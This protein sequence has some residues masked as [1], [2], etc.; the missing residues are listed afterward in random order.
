MFKNDY[1]CDAN[2]ASCVAGPNSAITKIKA[3]LNT[4]YNEFLVPGQDQAALI[5]YSTYAKTE[6]SL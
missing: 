5:T 3:S 6:V 2:F 1:T 4:M